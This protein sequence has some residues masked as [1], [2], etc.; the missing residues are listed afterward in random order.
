[1]A[2]DQAVLE[3]LPPEKL[4]A[5]T[6]LR[7]IRAAIRMFTDPESLDSYISHER[8]SWG[9]EG[10]LRLLRDRKNELSA[11]SDGI[12][13]D[14]KMKQYPTK[15]AHTEPLKIIHTE[16]EPRLIRREFAPDWNDL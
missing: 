6:R 14:G 7:I 12:P 9:R 2:T 11:P 1:M 10:I 3:T 5:A 13:Q 16:Y 4:L 8:N 15:A